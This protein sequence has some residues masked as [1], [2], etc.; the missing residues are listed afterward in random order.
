MSDSLILDEVMLNSSKLLTELMYSAFQHNQ[1]NDPDY[2][3]KQEQLPLRKTPSSC[4]ILPFL[5]KQISDIP[6]MHSGKC[7]SQIIINNKTSIFDKYQDYQLSFNAP[8]SICFRVRKVQIAL[9]TFLNFYIKF[10]IFFKEQGQFK[11]ISEWFYHTEQQQTFVIDIDQALN[12][13]QLYMVSFVERDY[14]RNLES[15]YEVFDNM[16]FPE[17]CKKFSFQSPFD[18]IDH[19][20]HH[21]EPEQNHLIL[22]S[23][24]NTDQ[25]GVLRQLVYIGYSHLFPNLSELI[26]ILPLQLQQPAP[27]QFF[28]PKMKNVA[29]D[30]I[31][32]TF[33]EQAEKGQSIKTAPLDF[34]FDMCFLSDGSI[35]L[36]NGIQQFQL[37]SQFQEQYL[38]TSSISPFNSLRSSENLQKLLIQSRYQSLN[39]YFQGSVQDFPRYL[40]VYSKLEHQSTHQIR[41]IINNLYLSILS[42][43]VTNLSSSSCRNILVKVEFKRGNEHLKS[44]CARASDGKLFSQL[45]SATYHEKSSRLCD[46]FKIDLPVILSNEYHILFTVYHL[47]FSSAE[48]DSVAKYTQSIDQS[49]TDNF[50][51]NDP[52]LL[53]L[54]DSKVVRKVGIGYLRLKNK[55]DFPF[56]IDL[57]REEDVIIVQSLG[58]SYWENS[59]G[60]QK[61]SLTQKFIPV[62]KVRVDLAS[63][64]SNLGDYSISSKRAD[65]YISVQQLLNNAMLFSQLYISSQNSQQLVKKFIFEY[66]NSTH[67]ILMQ[68]QQYLNGKKKLTTQ[69]SQ[70]VVSLMILLINNISLLDKIVFIDTN[71]KKDVY[72][73]HMKLCLGIGKLIRTENVILSVQQNQAYRFLQLYYGS[74]KSSH[75]HRIFSVDKETDP[76]Q[77]ILNQVKESA[78]KVQQQLLFKP[79]CL[80]SFI[81]TI[82]FNRDSIISQINFTVQ[83]IQYCITIQQYQEQMIQTLLYQSQLIFSL[84]DTHKND[85]DLQQSFSNLYQFS[86][87]FFSQF[88]YTPEGD[89]LDQ[90]PYF[91]LSLAKYIKIFNAPIVSF[92]NI[93]SQII[94]KSY[95]HFTYIFFP[96]LEALVQYQLRDPASPRESAVLYQSQMVE[97]F[98]TSLFFNDLVQKTY[99][100]T[101][102]S[103]RLLLNLEFTNFM[104]AFFSFLESTIKYIG[105]AYLSKDAYLNIYLFLVFIIKSSETI[106][107]NVIADQKFFQKLIVFFIDFSLTN[108]FYTEKENIQYFQ[109]QDFYIIIDLFQTNVIDIDSDC[110]QLSEDNCKIINF[111]QYYVTEK[112]VHQD[113]PLITSLKLYLSKIELKQYNYIQNCESTN[114]SVQTTKKYNYF[115]EQELEK[116]VNQKSNFDNETNKSSQTLPCQL[117]LDNQYHPEINS[118]YFMI[119]TSETNILIQDFIFYFRNYLQQI[120]NIEFR[121]LWLNFQSFSQLLKLRQI[122][123]DIQLQISNLLYYN[124]RQFIDCKQLKQNNILVVSGWDQLSKSFNSSSLQYSDI[125][126]RTADYFRG[127]T[128]LSFQDIFSCI[129]KQIWD[130]FVQHHQQDFSCILQLIQCSIE[131]EFVVMKQ[132]SPKLDLSFFNANSRLQDKIMLFADKEQ[133]QILFQQFE[134]LIIPI[135]LREDNLQLTFNNVLTSIVIRLK[136]SFEE[137][138]KQALEATVRVNQKDYTDVPKLLES[139]FKSITVYE[140]QVGLKKDMFERIFKL[141]KENDY[142]IE[143]AYCYLQMA[144]F[145]SYH[146]AIPLNQYLYSY[147]QIGQITNLITE[148]QFCFYPIV[149][150]I[151]QTITPQNIVQITENDVYIQYTDPKAFEKV[152]YYLQQSQ[153]IFKIYGL[154]ELVFL[155]DQG[156]K[157]LILYYYQSLP[158]I[159]QKKETKQLLAIYTL[160]K[161]FINNSQ[162]LIGLFYLISLHGQYLPDSFNDKQYIYHYQQNQ[163]I[164]DISN[165]LSI[166]YQ[167]YYK[168]ILTQQRI[169]ILPQKIVQIISEVDY[170]NRFLV[171]KIILQQQKKKEKIEDSNTIET[172][173][174]LADNYIERKKTYGDVLYIS[175]QEV[176]PFKYYSQ[177]ENQV[178]T[179]IVSDY[180]IK[181]FSDY[182]KSQAHIQQKSQKQV[183]NTYVNNFSAYNHV[184]NLKIQLNNHVFI[185]QLP[186]FENQQK[187]PNFTG[188]LVTYYMIFQPLPSHIIR[189]QI[190]KQFTLYFTPRITQAINLYEQANNLYNLRSSLSTPVQEQQINQMQSLL[191]GIFVPTV[192]MG[193]GI[194]FQKFNDQTPIFTTEKIFMNNNFDEYIQVMEDET[195]RYKY[196]NLKQLVIGIDQ[197]M[198]IF[199]HSVQ[200]LFQEGL[201]CLQVIK[202]NLDNYPQLTDV[203]NLVSK[204]ISEM[205][206]QIQQSI[207]NQSKQQ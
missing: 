5:Q 94:L 88:V 189:E 141:L 56:T 142:Q 136:S 14:G 122:N 205:K 118:L 197:E 144:S 6:I 24:D 170:K 44:I 47:S 93:N 155:L 55:K 157:D 42:L 3:Y 207:L 167:E 159:I 191:F 29:N 117:D 77:G 175:I 108:N 58:L 181:E 78:T 35:S 186:Y 192:Q 112:K 22:E 15:F 128:R 10:A 148:N 165:F 23:Y 206:Q 135:D 154:D 138:L 7:L 69:L 177:T 25:V 125:Y 194:L 54:K 82:K 19:Q 51:V 89:S 190:F 11:Q 13:K 39:L 53:Y 67:S 27:F 60:I 70:S 179:A 97:Q 92:E 74:T 72:L 48:P 149:N 174:N 120:Q 79:G 28:K 31:T 143:L 106:S 75:V 65:L 203:Y 83:L 193:P 73:L 119:D 184:F 12:L 182:F 49:Y 87:I 36:K 57:K 17:I 169:K 137:G 198:S 99:Y 37:Y 8:L 96:I 110:I 86:F 113:L 139:Y 121:D 131:F 2:L 64:I 163:R 183:S 185:S 166:Y 16:D 140:Q 132:A 129:Q 41:N 85:I 81:Q 161:T 200:F 158:E 18:L 127:N 95:N 152:L 50:L 21:L 107:Q 195:L 111:L 38:P 9:D 202:D 172:S 43:N 126:K 153:K 201:D 91:S 98:L 90:L 123:L 1:Y 68:I 59:P 164:S 147:G 160:N 130:L 187:E 33:Q 32:A 102:V 150:Q 196:P 30:L 100:D 173:L 46:T 162:R 34:Q 105:I 101:N 45:S 204:R 61:S 26:T 62:I 4:E 52:N 103:P 180:V 178:Q 63:N 151:I 66:S 71:Q 171:K 76:I 20:T 84:D 116:I 168:N 134:R 133:Q 188:K 114:Q 199:Y 40:H 176:Q 146:Y 104:N 109:I 80:A 115:K 145:I 124:F 156:I